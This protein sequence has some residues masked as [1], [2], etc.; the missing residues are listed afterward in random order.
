[1][2]DTDKYM[3][4]PPGGPAGPFWGVVSQKGRV[5]ALQIIDRP[6]ANLIV[7]VLNAL[8][9]D[10]ATM[11]AIC[12]RAAVAPGLVRVVL[13]ATMQVSEEVD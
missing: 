2:K 10:E 4:S 12:G 11:Q 3:L 5:V 8:N 1:M 9:G 7:S 13:Q 6:F